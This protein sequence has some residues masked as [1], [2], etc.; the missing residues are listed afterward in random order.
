M[1]VQDGRE[2][3]SL[4]EL[5]WSKLVGS[6]V[7]WVGRLEMWAGNSVVVWHPLIL[8]GIVQA[9]GADSQWHA[10]SAPCPFSESL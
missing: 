7:E 9:I 8:S 5:S 6:G 1:I 2:F 4:E 10:R 3:A